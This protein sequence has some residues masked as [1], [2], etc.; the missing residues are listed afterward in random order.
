MSQAKSTGPLLQRQ[1]LNKELHGTWQKFQT[2]EIIRPFTSSRNSYFKNEAKGKTF[3]VKMD[4]IRMRIK[5]HFHISD[6]ISLALKQR[7]KETQKWPNITHH[8][9]SQKCHLDYH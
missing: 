4:F 1:S 8:P 2:P 6:L 3:V 5:N 9:W 7:L